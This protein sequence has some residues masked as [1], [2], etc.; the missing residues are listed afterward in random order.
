ML[1]PH[2]LVSP[3]GSI[4]M[5][6]C[7][8]EALRLQLSGRAPKRSWAWRRARRRGVGAS[9]AAVHRDDRVCIAR[10]GSDVAV[11]VLRQ[12][13][14]RRDRAPR[15]ARSRA[16][17]LVARRDRREVPLQRDLR[18]GRRRAQRGRRGGRGRNALRA[19]PLERG[20]RLLRQRGLE[21]LAAPAN[22]EALPRPAR[23]DDDQHL[24]AIRV[25][26]G[27][28]VQVGPGPRR[29]RDPLRARHDELA[30]VAE[31]VVV[32]VVGDAAVPGVDG[33]EPGAAAAA[34]R[35][36]AVRG[37]EREVP[38]Q[39]RPR[40]VPRRADDEVHA[41][42]DEVVGP[43]RRPVPAAALREVD[44]L[45][46]VRVADDRLV[47]GDR[48][49][50][51][52]GRAGEVLARGRV[53]EN[54]DAV[55]RERP[56]VVECQEV[57]AL[58]R[59]RGAEVADEVDF[60]GSRQ[61]HAR[62]VG[63]LVLRLVPEREGRKREPASR[64]RVDE[65]REIGGVL[66]VVLGLQRAAVERARRLHPAGRAPGRAHQLERGIHLLRLEQDRD[67]M[68]L[69]GRDREV[70]EVAAR[71]VVRVVAKREVARAG[72][73]S[74]VREADPGRGRE[75]PVQELRALARRELGRHQPR[76]RVGHRGA[77]PVHLLV[78]MVLVDVDDEAIRLVPA[79]VEAR[80]R[81]EQLPAVARRQPG[82][83]RFARRG[84]GAG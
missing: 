3:H 71:V 18:L 32:V 24:R 77:E 36:R 83:D 81:L 29:R 13:D 5:P 66:V 67:P 60:V 51:V 8:V 78:A 39:H 30:E 15:P 44:R 40:P 42:P 21:R 61:P 4:P 37:V 63:R 57:D 73:D 17:H 7:D 59:E 9:S 11:D 80:L 27:D 70:G 76:R 25:A 47:V 33:H 20:H 56:V 58:A 6:D 22:G 48:A 84:R 16:L 50:A 53:R 23:V 54:V 68:R 2:P 46:R 62:I 14:A 55:M 10:P 43:V 65:P 28:R 72:R 31:R 74:H 64:P 38:L 75:E 69:V 26:E 49:V 45:V 35:M 82:A 34:A 12:P 41:V 19:V 1:W 79:E 52:E